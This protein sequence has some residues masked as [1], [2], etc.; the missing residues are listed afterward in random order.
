MSILTFWGRTTSVLTLATYLLIP[1]EQ[2]EAQVVNLAKCEGLWF[3]TS[4]DFLATAR[5]LSLIHI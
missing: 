3:S 2:A 4:E 5:S 1:P